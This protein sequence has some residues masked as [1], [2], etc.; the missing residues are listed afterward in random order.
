MKLKRQPRD[1][2]FTLLEVLIALSIFAIGSLGVL[3]M[4]TTTLALN[5]NSRQ[6]GEATQ[7]GILQME[8]LQVL[9]ATHADIAGCT[10]RCWLEENGTT[11]QTDAASESALR[12]AALL[13]QTAGSSL[14]YEVTWRIST[15][16]TRQFAE[17]KVFW[18]KNRNLGSLDWSTA[19][20]GGPLACHVAATAA[21]CYSVGFF[22]YIN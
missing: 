18:P 15:S 14:Y 21:K 4:M 6:S 12:P 8:R 9:P 13:A 10:G 1:A 11:F 5:Q 7:L 3:G 22:S 20:G 19:G 17:V 2:A 16:G